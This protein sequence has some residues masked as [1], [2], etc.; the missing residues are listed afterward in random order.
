MWKSTP[1]SNGFPGSTCAVL[2]TRRGATRWEYWAGAVGATSGASS[3]PL[4]R[5]P[6]CC[7]MAPDSTPAGDGRPLGSLAAVHGLGREGRQTDGHILGAFGLR[8]AVAHPLAGAREHRLAG[9]N[10]EHAALVVDAQHPPEDQRVLVELRRLS[11]L[12]PPGGAAHA[13]DA[14]RRRAGVH[15]TDILVDRLRLVARR[16]DA[17]GSRDQLRHGARF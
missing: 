7:R 15:A 11:R 17:G 5:R 1:T 9:A 4:I 13:R 6:L 12:L 10:V 2:A 16:D 8:R 14:H 3:S